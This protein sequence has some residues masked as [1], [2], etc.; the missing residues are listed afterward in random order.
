MNKSKESDKN[1]S[2][3]LKSYIVLNVRIKEQGGG[4]GII[5]FDVE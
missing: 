4:G 5:G 1:Y 2:P 3:T